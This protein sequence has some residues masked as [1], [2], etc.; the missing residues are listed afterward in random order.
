VFY[1]CKFEF[2]PCGEITIFIFYEELL[3]RRFIYKRSES[4]TTPYSEIEDYFDIKLWERKIK[5]G[6]LKK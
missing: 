5:L 6:N 1:K 3:G 4:T 2:E